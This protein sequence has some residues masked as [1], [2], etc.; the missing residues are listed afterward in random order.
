M[1]HVN[2]NTQAAAYVAPAVEVI[3]VQVE[4]GFA[5]SGGIEALGEEEIW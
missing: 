4:N 5:V 2:E 3:E 1:K